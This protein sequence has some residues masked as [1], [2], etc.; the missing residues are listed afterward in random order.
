[1]D[2]VQTGAGH[3]FQF[4]QM[5]GRG[6]IS[7]QAFRGGGGQSF[8]ALTFEGHLEATKNTLKIFAAAAV[9]DIFHNTTFIFH[10]NFVLSGFTFV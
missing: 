10:A 9:A 2:G 8:S 7:V 4:K 6:K 3:K 1:M 5:E